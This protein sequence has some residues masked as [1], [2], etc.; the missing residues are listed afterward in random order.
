[1]RYPP[2][3]PTHPP[4]YRI[5]HLQRV[6][7]T[8]EICNMISNAQSLHRGGGQGASAPSNF[9]TG[10]IA[11]ALFWSYC[12]K[13]KETT[14]DMLLNV[15]WWK[16]VHQIAYLRLHFQK[17]ALNFGGGHIPPDN[18]CIAQAWRLALLRRF[19]PSR[20]SLLPLWKSFHCTWKSHCGTE[21]EPSN[22][23]ELLTFHLVY[24]K[25]GFGENR[26][27]L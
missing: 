14:A 19:W 15:K 4:Q 18:P 21:L 24:V 10:G 7:T 17:K 3:S 23:N 22:L 16:I 26:L 6:K 25:F 13:V 1:M 20:Y 2:D 8:L 11:P 5:K 9:Q 12:S 27:L